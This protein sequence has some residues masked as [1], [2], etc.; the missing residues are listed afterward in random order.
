MVFTA[1]LYWVLIAVAGVM[2]LAPLSPVF[3]RFAQ[4]ADALILIL[5]CLDFWLTQKTSFL[6]AKRALSDRLS[7]GRRNSVLLTVENNGAMA[8]DCRLVDSFPDAIEA[9]PE[10]F[11]F[12]IAPGALTQLEY[13]LTP[14]RRGA[15]EFGRTFI[16]YRS[17]FGLFSFER[18]IDNKQNVKV[19]SD[20]IA[21]NELSIRLSRSNELGELHRNKRGQ[22]TDFSSLKE[23]VVGDDNK[24]IDWKATARRD[25]P[26]LR[27]YEVEQEQR[28][29][30]LVDAG[31]MMVS[32]LEGLTRFDHALN[33]A[34]ALVLTGLHH[35]DAVGI[36]IF[37]DRPL[38]YM[39]PRRGKGYLQKILE[40]TYNVQPSMVEPDYPTMLSYF[41]SQQKG[42]A[43]VVLLTDLTDP[44]GSEALLT[45]LVALRKRH[46][47]MCV[48]L[49]DRQILSLSQPNP[50]VE[51]QEKAVSPFKRAVAIDLISQRSLALNVLQRQGCLV[52]DKP[53]QDLSTGLID[54]Y[55]D[56][57]RRAL[58]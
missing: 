24:K 41:A 40:A 48:T 47:P 21:L 7:I 17:V 58:I 55:L 30:V 31:R 38:L 9:S 14:R 46:L 57:K 33:A 32:D 35:N 2:C 42:R 11:A 8:L 20:I 25:K 53:P 18:V 6:T 23:Y 34:L 49:N 15:Y 51:N 37:A 54:S 45:G 28:L 3:L 44:S 22:G 43:L 19:F 52:L 26:I 4:V 50:A 13:F 29:L 5:F 27:T 16:R 36:G 10:E 12:A 39:P 1:R 56:V